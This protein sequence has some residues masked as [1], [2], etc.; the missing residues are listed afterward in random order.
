[1]RMEGGRLGELP[2]LTYWGANPSLPKIDGAFHLPA[3][4]P[5]QC[6]PARVGYKPSTPRAPSLR[7]VERQRSGMR[8]SP[9]LLAASREW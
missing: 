1:M 2:G 4:P 8:G 5:L 3:W 9:W 7:G 6:S